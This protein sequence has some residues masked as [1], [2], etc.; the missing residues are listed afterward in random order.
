M[1]RQLKIS[2][3]D[4]VRQPLDVASAAAG[5][6]LGEEIRQRLERSLMGDLVD[7]STRQLTAAI[8]RFAR[9]LENDVAPWHASSIAHA[10]LANMVSMWIEAHPP[11]PSDLTT[12]PDLGLGFSNSDDP[13]IIARRLYRVDQII[14][15]TRAEIERHA[16]KGKRP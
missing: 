16:T 14:G 7:T 9:L 10:A 4:D 6:S 5:R 3:P 15:K 11:T 2:L 1:M 13:K 12:A 8:A